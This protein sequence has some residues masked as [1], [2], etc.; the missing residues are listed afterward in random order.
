MTDTDLVRK[1]LATN[2]DVGK[3]TVEQVLTSPL[4]TIESN[5][6]VDDAQDMMATSVCAP[7]RGDQR[8]LD[9]RRGIGARSLDALQTVRAR[10]AD[11]DVF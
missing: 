9:R 6:D 5:Q 11:P 1:G 7:P 2:Q 4:C 8:W 3:L 10:L